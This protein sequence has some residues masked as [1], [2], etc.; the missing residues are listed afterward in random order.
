MI[1]SSRAKEVDDISRE[2]IE[3]DNVIVDVDS[4]DHA[5]KDAKIHDQSVICKNESVLLV[6]T[7]KNDMSLPN[8]ENKS[9]SGD[10]EK[11]VVS[12]ISIEIDVNWFLKAI[13]NSIILRDNC[14]Y[15]EF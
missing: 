5:F 13:F 15:E 11:Y 4:H 8:D 9:K 10:I 7:S 6:F 14:L 3:G 2:D 12:F 1:P